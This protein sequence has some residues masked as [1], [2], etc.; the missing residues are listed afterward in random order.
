MRTILAAAA[1]IFATW[2]VLPHPSDAENRRALLVG[3]DHYD[4]GHAADG[5]SRS[6]SGGRRTWPNLRGSVNDATAIRELLIRRF[7]F[8]HQDV[9]LLTDEQA[10][11][12]EILEQFKRHL[13]DSAQPG[14]LSIFFYAGHGSRIRNS[15]STELDGK[16][17]TIVPA[18]ANRA[19]ADR[20]IIDIRDKEWDRL[21]TRVLDRGAKLTAIFDS[22]HS[23]SI[24]RGAVPTAA[25]VRF[26]EEDDRDVA[27][28]IGEEPPAHPS[29]QEP[30]RR[31]GALII[32]ATQEDQ[33]A[34]EALHRAGD[35]TE[36]HGAFTLALT[37]ALN[38]TAVNATA[39]R[40]MRRVTAKLKAEGLQ[41][42]PAVAG[43]EA[44]KRAPLFGGDPDGDVP[45]L[46]IN[47][48]R[49]YGP[50]DV[51]VQ[52]GS[53]IGLTNGTELVSAAG[54][55][56][57]RIAN[58]RN[59]ARSQAAVVQGDWNRLKP[60]DEFEVSRKGNADPAALRI[61]LPPAVKNL[62]EAEHLAAGLHDHLLQIGMT[63]VVEPTEQS[64][65]HLLTWNGSEWLLH[66]PDGRTQKV[67]AAPTAKQI[68]ERLQKERAPIRLYMNIPPSAALQRILTASIETIPNPIR[69]VKN[70][71]EAQYV[72]LGRL[73][74]GHV[75]YAWALRN[76]I[77]SAASEK[78]D[79]PMP[80]PVHTLWGT[81]N[82][83]PMDCAHGGLQSCLAGLARIHQ[84]LSIKSSPDDRRF[85]YELTFRP[86]ASTPAAGSGTLR[87]GAYRL[88]LESDRETI[89]NIQQTWGIQQRYVYVFVIDQSGRSTLLFPNDASKEYEN[90]I[91][92]KGFEKKSPEHLA[93]IDLGDSGVMRVHAPFGVDTFILLTTAHEIQQARQ[94]IESEAVAGSGQETRGQ[95]DWSI[96]RQF[97]RSL[98]A[99][100]GDGAVP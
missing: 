4:G 63:W 28:L 34:K 84:W 80:L 41:Q 77:R 59:L 69:L 47:V 45:K 37:E 6:S 62:H 40:I 57:L 2:L 29:G 31:E 46:R 54:A 73:S 65:T 3:I 23:G 8:R 79:S 48:V 32:S 51:D 19:Q 83:K 5:P 38:E 67:G 100:A 39:D 85:P 66:G 78:A 22:C 99:N 25:Q 50:H 56:R 24:S 55:V 93:M 68:A 9:I 87:E 71:D 17:E 72:L 44:R 36:W 26:L 64:P 42:D 96:T 1:C 82:D 20:T 13:I 11:R 30:E 10:T 61:W 95:S 60:G 98:P 53:A 27:V 97:R 7:G 81:F 58:V 76:P 35:Q 74:D 15:N 12:A 92:P 70:S 89:K 52:G 18:D 21:F 88:M 14:D 16:D 91:P 86:A 94:L 49:A 90:L 33:Q 75:H 43:A